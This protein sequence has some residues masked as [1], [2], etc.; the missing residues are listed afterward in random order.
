MSESRTRRDDAQ[1][2]Q[3]IALDQCEPSRSCDEADQQVADDARQPDAVRERPADIRGEQQ[4]PERQRRA[5]LDR[6]LSAGRARESL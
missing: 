1:D 6:N 3:L 5:R 2:L 4:Q